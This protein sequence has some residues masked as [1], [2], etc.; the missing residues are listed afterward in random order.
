MPKV[1]FLPDGLSIEVAPGT[2]LLEAALRAKAQVGHAC[3]GKCACSTCHVYVR[4]GLASLSEQRENEE[5]ILDKAFDL[6][7]NSRL[8]CQTRLG[9]ADVAVEISRESRLAYLDEHPGEA[10]AGK[11]A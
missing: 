7:P 10:P 9:A 8:S 2:T 1:T 3:G 6:R 11:D 4:E 5:D